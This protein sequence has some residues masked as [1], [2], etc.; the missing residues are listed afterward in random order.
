MKT[1]ATRVDPSQVSKEE[2]VRKASQETIL[3]IRTK[4]RR[5]LTAISATS[6]EQS[7]RNKE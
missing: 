6:R 7:V 4:D 3:T 2:Q 1:T 5:I